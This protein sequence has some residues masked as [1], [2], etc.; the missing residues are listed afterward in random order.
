MLR[1][2]TLLIRAGAVVTVAVAAWIVFVSLKQVE[3]NRHIEEEVALLQDEADRIRRENETLTEKI[4]YFSSDAFREQEAKRKLGL[5]KPGETAVAIRT[6]TEAE[7]PDG[8]EGWSRKALQTG[9]VES[10]EIGMKNYAA[11]WRVFF[12]GQ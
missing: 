3:R 4:R 5:R 2:R 10:P 12:G 9:A 7:T 8:S 1:Q 11:W 6:Q